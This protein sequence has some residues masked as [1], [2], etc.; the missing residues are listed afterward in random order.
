MLINK[1][2]QLQ[3]SPSHQL[4]DIQLGTADLCLEQ[5]LINGCYSNVSDI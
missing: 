1:I 5:K 2:F 4:I 3:K